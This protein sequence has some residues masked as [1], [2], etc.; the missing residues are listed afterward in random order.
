MQIIKIIDFTYTTIIK[1]IAKDLWMWPGEIKLGRAI[2]SF[3]HRQLGYS[4]PRTPQSAPSGAGGLTAVWSLMNL[5]KNRFFSKFMP[6]VHFM[7]AE[8]DG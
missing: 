8:T 2:L 7:S 4:S 6:T 5:F 1:I 3:C